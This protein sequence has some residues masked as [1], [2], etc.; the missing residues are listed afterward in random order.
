MRQWLPGA[1]FFA[2][3]FM[4][5]WFAAVHAIPTIA[6]DLLWRQFLAGSS[7]INVLNRPRLR[8]AKRNLVVM[9]NA[10]TVTRSVIYDLSRGPLLFEAEVPGDMEYWSVAVYAHNTDTLFVANDQDT[11]AG[12]FRLVISRSGENAQIGTDRVVVSPTE[13]GFLILRGVVRDRT[14]P[15][16]VEQTIARMAKARISP[17]RGGT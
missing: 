10:D 2:A 13:R 1:L 11:G 9:D 17:S 3:M 8:S 14:N 12:P 6:T 5:G 7:R 15:T 16:E 4:I